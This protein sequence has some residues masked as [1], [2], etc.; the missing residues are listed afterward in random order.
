[1]RSTDLEEREGSPSG[2]VVP[3]GSPAGAGRRAN[4][5]RTQVSEPAEAARKT[6]AQRESGQEELAALSLLENAPIPGHPV[7]S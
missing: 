3:R 1:M 6:C 7:I 5:T 2:S 4:C